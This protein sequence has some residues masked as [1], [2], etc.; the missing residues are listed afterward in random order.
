MSSRKINRTLTNVTGLAP[1]LTTLV[2]AQSGFQV[3]PTKIVISNQLATLVD[4][5]LYEETSEIYSIVLGGS[6]TFVDDKPGGAGY[7]LA[8]SSGLFS[9]LDN[10]GSV[11]IT[12]FYVN[13]DDRQGIQKHTAR[14]NS[15]N[16][17]PKA[18]RRPNSFGNQ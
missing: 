9:A 7:R 5:Q 16:P 6:G 12:V 13:H 2:P 3:E 14:F 10:S 18:I 8:R 11:N 15:L 17:T 4:V 1:S